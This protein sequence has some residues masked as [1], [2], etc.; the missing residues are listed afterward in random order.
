M[1]AF[2]KQ[3]GPKGEAARR[4]WLKQEHQLGSNYAKWLA[5]SR[6]SQTRTVS[7]RWSTGR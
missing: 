3:H 5:L 2:I 6:L 7:R 1:V 4:D